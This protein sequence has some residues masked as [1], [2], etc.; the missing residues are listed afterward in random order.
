M[1]GA[2]A[3]ATLRRLW[4]E[5]GADWHHS[6]HGTLRRRVSS[7]LESLSVGRR[8]GDEANI[9]TESGAAKA[10]AR[11][12]RPDEFEQRPNNSE[13]ATCKGPKTPGSCDPLQVAALMRTGRFKR[14][15]RVLR[16]RDFQRIGRVGRRRATPF[17][18]V[19]IAS[20]NGEVGVERSRLGMMV[21][22]RVGNAVA[23]NRV[24]RAV[25]E[26]FRHHRGEFEEC[27]EVVVIARR[28]AAELSTREIGKILK[29]LLLPGK[30]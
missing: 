23:R 26:W 6:C 29:E 30:R 1:A 22:R 9:S 4:I 8:R 12:S 7:Q 2:E 3:I 5:G 15:D 11:V 10:K 28:G 17:F 13:A 25:R 18:A 27:V 21:G 16:R 20:A 19:L 24:K 14:G